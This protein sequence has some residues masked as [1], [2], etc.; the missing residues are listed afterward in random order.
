MRLASTRKRF[1]DWLDGASKWDLLAKIGNSK[2]VGY[3]SLIPLIGYM[4]LFNERI[5]SYLEIAPSFEKPIIPYVSNLTFRL[6]C[7][8]FGLCA[9]AVSSIIYKKRCAKIVKEYIYIA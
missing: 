5:T 1:F 6:Y 8:Y 7:M 3:V 9:V 4:I 2:V